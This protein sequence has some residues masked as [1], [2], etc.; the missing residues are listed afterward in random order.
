MKINLSRTLWS[1]ALVLG[2]LS[3]AI[4][5]L[6]NYRMTHFYCQNEVSVVQN[7]TILNLISS[8]DFNGDKG[9]YRSS[10]QIGQAGQIFEDATQSV[11]FDFWYMSGQIVAVSTDNNAHIKNL[12]KFPV[13]IPSFFLHRGSGIALELIKINASAYL[14]T[15]EKTPFFYCKL[16]S[17][18]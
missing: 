6:V 18:T 13:F 17:A 3:A 9:K 1:L 8:F 15:K 16:A 11:S 2:V 10:G 14:I 12:E 4:Y 5:Y 7:D